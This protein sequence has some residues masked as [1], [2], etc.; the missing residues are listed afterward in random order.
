MPAGPVALERPR[1]VVAHPDHAHR[2]AAV[3][4]VELDVEGDDGARVVPSGAVV[5]M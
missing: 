2:F 5:A 4:H 1:R 3:V